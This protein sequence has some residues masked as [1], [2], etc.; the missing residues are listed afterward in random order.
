MV[1]HVVRM[2][3]DMAATTTIR[4]SE[5]LKARIAKVAKKS[6]TTA[7]AFILDAIAQKTEMAERYAAFLKEA[8]D[9][10]KEF[11]ETGMAISWEDMESVLLAR[12]EGKDVPWPAPRKIV[13]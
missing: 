13:R 11:H 4:I 10:R 6:G 3:I 5:K 12:A 9:R 1:L 2:R 8:D 7:H